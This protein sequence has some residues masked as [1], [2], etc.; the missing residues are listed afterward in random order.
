[1]NKA[2]LALVLAFFTAGAWAQAPVET[3][4]AAAQKHM[5]QSDNPRLAA[6]KKLVFDFW[7]KVF[8]THDVTTL[9]HY[10]SKSYIQHNPNIASGLPPFI[11]YFGKLKRRPVKSTIDNLVTMVAEDDKVILAF[12]RVLP[13][14]AHPK[15]T[16]TTTWFDMFRIKAGKIVEHWDCG[17]KPVK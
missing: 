14:P 17:T 10:V 2:I 1:M 6:N 12:K 16:Y 11:N 5:L 8:Q 15:R 9:R 7:R 4:T 3:A 13:D